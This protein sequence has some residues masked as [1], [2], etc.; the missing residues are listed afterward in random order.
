M[1]FSLLSWNVET[2]T[3]TESKLSNVAIHVK[4]LN[5]DVVGFFEVE[6]VN[7]ISLMNN[8]LPEYD[9]NLTDGPENKEIL[10]GVRRAKF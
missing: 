4:S 10:I 2:F 9:Y 5:P 7:I 3:G 6:N 8:H 1:K